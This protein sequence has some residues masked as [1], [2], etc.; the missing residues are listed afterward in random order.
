MKRILLFLLIAMLLLSGCGTGGGATETEGTEALVTE[1]ETIS[2]E[3]K[4]EETDVNI[5]ETPK[6]LDT[7]LG[8]HKPST[9]TV[10]AIEDT[11]IEAGSSSDKN[12]GTSTD[13]DLKGC[14]TE[15]QYFRVP[16][17]KF[18][19][20]PLYD[21]GISKIYLSLNCYSM[22]TLPVPT[23][24]HIY[25]CNP[26]D[27]DEA[28]LTF[29]KRPERGE[30]ILETE[31]SSVGVLHIDITEYVLNCIEEG[32]SKISLWLE[33]L[34]KPKGRLHFYSKESTTESNRPALVV[35]GGEIGFTTDLKYDGA[36]P[37]E[38]AMT[39]VNTWFARWE[40][41]KAKGDS[42][43][44]PLSQIDAE[45]SLSVD[46]ASLEDTNGEKTKYQSYPTRTM[47]TLIGYTE[48][49]GETALYDMYGGYTGDGQYGEATGFF[50]TKKIGDRYWVI[51]PQGYP[52][53]RTA[54]VTVTAG[55]G[56]Q[57]TAALAKYGSIAGW[58]NGAT[59]RLRELGFN[60]TGGWS[61]LESLIEVEKPL[62][63]TKILGLM[64]GYTKTLGSNITDS[65]NIKVKGNV[66]PVFD[67]TFVSY[68]DRT[69]RKE[70]TPYANSSEIYGW[71]SDNE[72]S[73]ISM[74]LDNALALDPED[75]L[76]VYSYATA[77][78]FMYMKTGNP[79]VSVADVTK[80]LRLEYRAMIYDRYFE[81]VCGAIREYAPNHLYMGCRFTTLLYKD[82]AVLRVAGHWCDIVTLNYYY[83]WTAD[84]TVMNNIEK[85]SGKPFAVTEWYAKG[86]D[87]W[88]AD[89]RMTNQSGA[90]W[91]VRTQDDRGKFYHNFALSLMECGGCVGF[92]WFK[93]WDNDPTDLD[94]DPSNRNA[95]KGIYTNEYEEYTELTSMMERLNNQKYRLIDFFDGRQ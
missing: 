51:D 13:L 20:T 31:V 74:M 32:E 7:I 68:C 35:H 95:N 44:A 50:Y 3:T 93:Y 82:E 42:A 49:R 41:I 59:T 12:F 62:A 70:V 71:M 5:P 24:F 64:A 92:D 22:E 56:R 6:G 33:G 60:S 63:Q 4:Q 79:Y 26:D 36:N 21:M 86:M 91:T 72:L 11:Y 67:P 65:G 89:P 55:R 27:W 61:S 38:L 54:C 76:Y 85:W 2:D 25:A 87:V 53:Y 80:E 81:V 8:L 1:S 94:V 17:L 28:T 69:V 83:A 88:E 9:T 30:K 47:D 14:E 48:D 78:T 52:F 77:W 10:V 23:P 84:A 40:E 90:G 37:W 46:A 34:A 15:N 29:N 58:A 39:Y 66:M 75:P 45:Y 57:Q 43:A 73:Q 16:L 19:I 18:D